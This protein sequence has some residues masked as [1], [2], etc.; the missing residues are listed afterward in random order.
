MS[1][2]AVAPDPAATPV[3]MAGAGI[4]LGERAGEIRRPGRGVTA[5]LAPGMRGNAPSPGRERGKPGTRP[6]AAAGRFL[7]TRRASGHVGRLSEERIRQRE[8]GA[9]DRRPRMTA[10]CT[11]A[12]A[13]AVAPGPAATP[14]GMAC[15]QRTRRDGMRSGTPP[16]DGGSH[17]Q[18]HGMQAVLSHAPGETPAPRRSAALL[19]RNAPLLMA[20]R[21][22]ARDAAG[23]AAP[24]A[25]MTGG[26]A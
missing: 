2:P 22:P 23:G 9:P 17:H 14:V 4:S 15:R 5:C 6:R 18:R 10:H 12:H 19:C 24:T 26:P 3:G 13:R 1:G 16:C 7:R 20:D 21:A 11:L 25:T 8:H